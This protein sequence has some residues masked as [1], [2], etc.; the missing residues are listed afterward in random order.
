LVD[1]EVISKKNGKKGKGKR[2]RRKGKKKKKGATD[3][4]M[5]L[6]RRTGSGLLNFNGEQFKT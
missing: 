4:A 2:G 3:R 6:P 5:A 1:L